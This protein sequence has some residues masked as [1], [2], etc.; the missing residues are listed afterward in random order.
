MCSSDLSIL[1]GKLTTYRQMAEDTVDVLVRRD[2]RRIAC[3]TRTLVIDGG[4]QPEETA[5]AL[6]AAVA[7]AGLPAETASHLYRTYGARGQRILALAREPGLAR[8]LVRD[9]PTL[10]AEVVYGCREEQLVS[11]TDF[12]FFR[13]R[14][15]ILDRGHG[16]DAVATIVALMTEE[17]GWTAAEQTGQVAAYEDVLARETAFMQAAHREGSHGAT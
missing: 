8:P 11:L 17:L 15:A 13:S 4:E 9:L 14:L 6:A 3:R 10:A 5:G 1:G 7:D 16:R 12:M 2:G